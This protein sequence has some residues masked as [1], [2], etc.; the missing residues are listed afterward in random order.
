MTVARIE[1][2]PTHTVLDSKISE[3][4]LYLYT[5]YYEQIIIFSR[6]VP[7]VF[8]RTCHIIIYWMEPNILGFEPIQL[9]LTSR[10]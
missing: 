2:V 4:S 6:V 3:Q 10:D 8:L 7:R 1:R 9:Y 5:R